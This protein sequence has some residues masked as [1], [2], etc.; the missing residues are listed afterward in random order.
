MSDF[1]DNTEDWAPVDADGDGRP[2]WSS[3]DTSDGTVERFDMPDG[4][5]VLS[6]D[7]DG[8][9]DFESIASDAD[10]DGTP[11]IVQSDADGDG[12]PESLEFPGLDGLA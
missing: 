3:A 1:W 12:V 5:E 11:E 8:D 4:G 6:L 2:D 7:A 10:G 9:G